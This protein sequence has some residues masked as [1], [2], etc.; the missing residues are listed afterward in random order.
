MNTTTPYLASQKL[1]QDGFEELTRLKNL[2]RH[3]RGDIEC[4]LSTALLQAGID[5]PRFIPNKLDISKL[6][7]VVPTAGQRSAHTNVQYHALRQVS[8]NAMNERQRDIYRRFCISN[9][10]F[11]THPLLTWAQLAPYLTISELTVLGDSMMRRNPVHFSYTVDDFR[12]LLSA[13]PARFLHRRKCERALLLM[14]PQTD[15]PMETRFRLKLDATGIPELRNLAVNHAVA[16]PPNGS[17]AYLDL[18]IVNLRIGID[19][20]GR[21]H[22]NQWEADEAR[23]TA[24]LSAGWIIATANHTTIEN[25]NA[26]KEFVAQLRHMIFQQSRI[27]GVTDALAPHSPHLA[28]YFATLRMEILC[29]Q[30]ICSVCSDKMAEFQRF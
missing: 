4:C 15:S 8:T 6:H 18:A 16:L 1:L 19:Y 3:V 10:I 30:R 20:S 14:R 7:L 25:A 9:G 12:K 24:L 23:R 11:M 26:W 29:S 22:A 2:T 21:H 13:L 27:L 17:K 28:D 5:L